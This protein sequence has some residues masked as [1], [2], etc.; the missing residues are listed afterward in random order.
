MHRHGGENVPPKPY[1]ALG[2]R[3]TAIGV[4][5]SNLTLYIHFANGN[6]SVKADFW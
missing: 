4:P 6:R 5:V 2:G 3:G 1:G